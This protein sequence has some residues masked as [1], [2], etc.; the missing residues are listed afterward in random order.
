MRTVQQRVS[1]REGLHQ[2]KEEQRRS[3]SSFRGA[4]NRRADA[5]APAPTHTRRLLVY[6]RG[7]GGRVVVLF[8]F[9]VRRRPSKSGPPIAHDVN[10]YWP[11]TASLMEPFGALPNE[12]VDPNSLK[13][14]VGPCGLEPQTST[15]SKT[16]VF[17]DLED[18]V[19][20]KKT[21]KHASA[22]T[23]WS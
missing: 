4:R 20:R 11:W 2:V 3:K 12:V 21:Q 5:V 13:D 14:M 23:V 18:A 1:I 8:A 22:V 9:E 7:S 19:A 15:V 17:N 16:S 6:A 10:S